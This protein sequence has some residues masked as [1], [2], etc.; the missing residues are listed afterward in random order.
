MD[1]LWRKISDAEKERVKKDAKNIMKSFSEK[2]SGV[3]NLKED[4]IE[5]HEFERNEG[6]GKVCE[7]DFRKTML[8]N[9][10]VKEGDFIV[11]EKGAW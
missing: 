10:P 3:E 8:D 11:A 1:F 4:F 9:S 7:D 6:D 2:L 5:R